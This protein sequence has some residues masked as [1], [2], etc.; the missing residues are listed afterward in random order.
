MGNQT[1]KI[2]LASLTIAGAA[3]TLFF[4][5]Y[6]LPPRLDAVPHEALG[7]AVAQEASK[8]LGSGGRILLIA[9]DTRT[10][11]NP[12]ADVQIRSFLQT[13]KQSGLR[14]GFTNLVKLDPLRVVGVPPGD[15]FQILK[16]GSDADVVVSFLGP[17]TLSEEQVA[18]L[19]DKAPKVI[20]VCTGEMPRQVNLKRLFEQKLLHAAVISRRGLAAAPPASGRGREWF[21]YLFAMV[22]PG[23]F[24]ELPAPAADGR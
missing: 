15:F 23:D 5:F 17:A 19:G 9:R 11:P 10:F 16:R 3:L 8:L 20:A 13:L 22:R 6:P 21:D 14:V 1:I 4:T 7:Q 2:T 18:K 24:S 12:A